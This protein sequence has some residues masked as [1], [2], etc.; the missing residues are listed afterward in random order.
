MIKV[1]A[2]TF[3][4]VEPTAL[5]RAR[6]VRASEQRTVHEAGR[7]EGVSEGEFVVQVPP[8]TRFIRVSVRKDADR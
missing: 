1:E 3:T 5:Q 7:F 4:I 6:G 8:G 2:E